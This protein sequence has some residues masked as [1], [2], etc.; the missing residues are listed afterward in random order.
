VLAAKVAIVAGAGK[1]THV[2]EEAGVGTPQNAGMQ[3]SPITEVTI[4]LHSEEEEVEDRVRHRHLHRQVVDQVVAGTTNQV[5][6]SRNLAATTSAVARDSTA[7]TGREQVGAL[8]VP[9]RAIHRLV[10]TTPRQFVARLPAVRPSSRPFAE[11]DE[12]VCTLR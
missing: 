7:S 11:D 6:G 9:N 5:T 3:S 4:A 8:S 2:A 1:E 10:G 12:E